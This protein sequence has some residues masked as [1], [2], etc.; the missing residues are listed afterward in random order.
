MVV[1]HQKTIC[2]VPTDLVTQFRFRVPKSRN[3]FEE[4]EELESLAT[5]YKME[6]GLSGQDRA[7]TS[8]V[9]LAN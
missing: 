8:I 7:R 2:K 4:V 1:S 6:V 9:A 3:F 5:L